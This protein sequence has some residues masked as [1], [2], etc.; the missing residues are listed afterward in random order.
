M[1]GYRINASVI[2]NKL[3]YFNGTIGKQQNGF[4][5]RGL[6]MMGTSALKLIIGKQRIQYQNSLSLYRL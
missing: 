5:R 6:A 3:K 4:C 2:K 1:Y